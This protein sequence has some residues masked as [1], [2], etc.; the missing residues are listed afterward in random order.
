MPTDKSHSD[1]QAYVTKLSTK[2]DELRKAVSN[3]IGPGKS[4]KSPDELVAEDYEFAQL[5][6][7]QFFNDKTKTNQSNFKS[8]IA[9]FQRSTTVK[10]ANVVCHI[11]WPDDLVLKAYRLAAPNLQ[12]EGLARKLTA[13]RH[14]LAPDTEKREMQGRKDRRRYVVLTPLQRALA[15]QLSDLS[16]LCETDAQHSE[17]CIR[18]L[19]AL[20]E[21]GYPALACY[22]RM[23]QGL[24]RI[25]SQADGYMS[26][27][28]HKEWESPGEGHVPSRFVDIPSIN[29]L[30]DALELWAEKR[31]TS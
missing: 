4:Q 3:G 30:C 15:W 12:E 29:R 2:R 20:L 11:H 21:S 28:T 6:A 1:R 16:A 24:G 31:A 22:H 14:R 18:V 26:S 8:P 5:I 10:V 17:T 13:S 27:R 7:K 9:I 25:E 19:N 23:I